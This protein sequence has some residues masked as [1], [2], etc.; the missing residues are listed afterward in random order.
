VSFLRVLQEIRI[1]FSCRF[2]EQEVYL[3]YSIPVVFLV[4][5]FRKR[6]VY[7]LNKICQYIF[8]WLSQISTVASR[9]R[10]LEQIS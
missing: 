5:K 2:F 4:K 3:Y 7:K 6:T 10:T 8:F 9:I 1:H